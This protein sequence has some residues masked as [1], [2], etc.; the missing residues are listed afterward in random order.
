MSR[1]TPDYTALGLAALAGAVGALM[2][3]G[4]WN[5]LAEWSEQ[6]PSHQNRHRRR[7]S[8][9]EEA[10]NKRQIKAINFDMDGT[11]IKT[12]LIWFSLLKDAMEAFNCSH[13]SELQ[14]DDWLKNHFG[15][16][17][18]A[19]VD[20]WFPG[21]T[22]EQLDEYCCAH[23]EKYISLLEI[24]PHVESILEFSNQVTNN[25]TY[26]ITNCPRPISE[27]ILNSEKGKVFSKYFLNPDG[28]LR[29]LCPGD[30]G[31]ISNSP[32]LPKPS[33]SMPSEVSR[34]FKI[35]AHDMILVGDSVFDIETIQTAGGVGILLNDST[36]APSTTQASVDDVKH[37]FLKIAN[38]SE[39]FQIQNLFNFPA[40]SGTHK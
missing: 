29:I 10:F 25:H 22:V 1:P 35:S 3:Q 2:A 28:T 39:L 17:M 6:K 40:I 31:P 23:Y 21:I 38:L 16:S 15:Q 32:L 8:M 34:L 11:L 36:T 26:I 27:I 14:Y 19:N 12:E 33:I 30:N 4:V 13:Q 9:T 37:P 7:V 18:Q 5:L 24:M 20:C